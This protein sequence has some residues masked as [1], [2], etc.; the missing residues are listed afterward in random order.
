MVV[1]GSGGGDNNLNSVR[2]PNNM[3]K[4]NSVRRL[5]A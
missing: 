4:L 2:R 5:R 3:K 1:V